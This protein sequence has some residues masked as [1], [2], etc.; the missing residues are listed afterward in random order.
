MKK[1]KINKTPFMGFFLLIELVA[2][3]VSVLV[4]VYLTN[5][6]SLK[7]RYEAEYSDKISLCQDNGFDLLVGGAS[8]E[9]IEEFKTKDFVT[10]VS[11]ASKLS[12]SVKTDSVEDYRDILVFN[13]ID[14]LEYSEFTTKRMISETNASRFIYADYK[15]CDLYNVS[16]GDE[17][18]ITINGEH[19]NYVISRVYRTN[20]LYSEGVL[21][22]TKDMIPLSSKALYAYL[23]AN[24]KENLI[25]YLQDY[26]PLGTLLSKTPSQSDEDYQNYLNEFNSKKYYSSCVT[27]LS[28]QSDEVINDYSKKLSSS[29]TEFYISIVIVSMVTFMTSLICFFVNA[30]NKKDKV[31]KYIQENGNE[32]IFKIYTAFNSSFVVFMLIGIL[33]SMGI[34]SLVATTYYTFFNVLFE[35]YVAIIASIV[36]ILAGYLISAIKIKKA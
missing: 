23:N 19:C 35:S 9:Q 24:N 11:F 21:V 7:S 12:L 1:N 30:K 32:K 10:H 6:I 29:T 31:Y 16:L 4:S 34:A 27:D 36:S 22:T 2:F 14:D 20:Y 15:F 18:N 28:K 8:S 3:V 25:S 13:S 5:T 17:I 33:V 26:K